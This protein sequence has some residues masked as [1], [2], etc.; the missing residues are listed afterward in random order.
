MWSVMLV[1]DEP[2]VVEGLR[3]HVD[4]V[5]FGAE[6]GGVAYNGREALALFERLKPNIVITDIY[7]P[8][9]DGLELMEAIRTR[10]PHTAFVILSGYDTFEYAQ[11]SLRFGAVDYLLKPATLDEITAVIGKAVQHC[12]DSVLRRRL[13]EELPCLREYFLLRLLRNDGNAEEAQFLGLSALL[14]GPFSVA[15]VSLE[16]PR[17]TSEADWQMM[18]LFARDAATGDGVYA[19]PHWGSEMPVVLHRPAD[20]SGWCRA[21]LEKLQAGCA[22]TVTIGLSR[23]A[24]TVREAY[25]QAREA[26]GYKEILGTGRLISGDRVTLEADMLPAY[27]LEQ[28]R[29]L[30]EAI[31]YGDA[32]EVSRQ[33]RELY[34]SL[35]KAPASYVRGVS[36]ELYG[37]AAT[38]MS[39]RGQ[40]MEELCP[41]EQFWTGVGTASPEEVGAWVEDRLCEV[42]G[43]LNVRRETRHNRVLK[44]LEVLIA[45]RYA[46]DLTLE[47]LAKS[48]YLSRTYVAWLFKQLK[49]CSFLEYLTRFRMEKAKELL[50]ATDRS[51]CDIAEQ[52]GYKNAAY[53]SR[54]FREHFGQ[55]PSELRRGLPVG[56]GSRV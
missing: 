35:K 54:I 53:F 39:E 12:R 28:N 34:R 13:E 29:S 41:L 52:V 6:V 8:G 20:A 55:M 42:A 26:L 18:R 10:A 43:R 44:E 11:R 46:E 38:A 37:L 25:A 47:S 3:D 49:G 1:D 17:E 56:G 4:W 32:G 7:M 30:L 31:R 40:A 9:M 19:L 33:V 15:L 24:P 2:A 22:A 27:P 21:L 45:A 23:S 16:R 51:V 36:L 50:V 5:S 14:E 48:V